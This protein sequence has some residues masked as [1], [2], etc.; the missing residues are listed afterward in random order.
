MKKGFTLVE[1]SIVI[2]IIALLSG[3]VISGRSLLDSYKKQTVLS[4]LKKVEVAYYKFTQ[5]Y[6]SMPGDMDDATR[7]WPSTTNGDGNESIG[8]NGLSDGVGGLSLEPLFFWQQLD[9]SKI[10]E[11]FGS[12]GAFVP[13]AGA[14]R[15]NGNV[16]SG[17]YSN[18]FYEVYSWWS[19][20]G[21]KV[22]NANLV[23]NTYQPLKNG[24][25]VPVVP[26]EDAYFL[27][28]KIDD[29]Y[30]NSGK[31]AISTGTE[32][33]SLAAANCYLI[34]GGHAVYSGKGKCVLSYHID[35]GDGW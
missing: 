20:G 8:Y 23:L 21:E 16:P 1:M 25:N 30:G 3:A 9:L 22:A 29:G 5:K 11:G 28:K 6:E 2:L 31:I 10:L 34:S 27:D 17:P 35:G 13:G 19:A 24:S 32:G 7:F 18:S 33:W 12:D 14:Y 15:I 26:S 4:D